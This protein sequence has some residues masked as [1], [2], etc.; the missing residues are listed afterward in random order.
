LGKIKISI[1]RSQDLIQ[2]L[3]LLPYSLF[4]RFLAGK[5]AAS[6]CLCPARSYRKKYRL[7]SFFAGLA[8]ILVLIS[9]TTSQ[10]EFLLEADENG[11]LHATLRDTTLEEVSSFFTKNYH[12]KFVGDADQLQTRVTLAFEKLSVEKALKKIFSKMNIAI[13]FDSRGDITEVRVLPTGPK[14]TNTGLVSN[15]VDKTAQALALEEDEPDLAD[16]QSVDETDL[17]GAE[18]EPPA[19]DETNQVDQGDLPADDSFEIVPNSPPSEDDFE[20]VPSEP[21]SGS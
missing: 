17:L 12:I 8:G 6:K 9:F 3:S 10:A 2:A 1:K 20:I 7:F 19:A 21:P 11:Q 4:S 5:Q 14:T 15:F 16:V 18:P 13:K